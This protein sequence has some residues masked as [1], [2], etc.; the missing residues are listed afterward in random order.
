MALQVNKKRWKSQ[1]VFG[2]WIYKY[3][4]DLKS[5][6]ARKNAGRGQALWGDRIVFSWSFVSFLSR[7]KKR[8]NFKEQLNGQH[9]RKEAALQWKHIEDERNKARVYNKRYI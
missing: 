1:V 2:T 3:E 6:V 4:Q 7:K 9:K 8:M 5:A